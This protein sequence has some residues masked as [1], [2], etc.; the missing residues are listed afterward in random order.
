MEDFE[1]QKG[2][3]TCISW[4]PSS[5]DPRPMLAVGSLEPLVKIWEYNENHRKWVQVETLTGHTS[6]IHDV[7]WA[8]NMG[9]AYHLIATASKD[10]KVKIW[11]LTLL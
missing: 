8:P 6:G 3:V 10:Q 2:G 11:K 7:S 5:L 1:A 4:N 9:R